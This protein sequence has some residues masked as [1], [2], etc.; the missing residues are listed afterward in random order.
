[1]LNL[2]LKVVTF[3]SFRNTESPSDFLLLR[4]LS[5]FDVE[6]SINFIPVLTMFCE[7]I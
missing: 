1:M 7:D 3:K 6:D 4:F 2:S 5:L